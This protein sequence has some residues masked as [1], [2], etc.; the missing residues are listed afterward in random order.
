MADF[1]D[2]TTSAT[3]IQTQLATVGTNL[4]QLDRDLGEVERV[5]NR[6]QATTSEARA[7]VSQSRHDL[8]GSSDSMRLMLVLLGLVVALGQIVPLWLGF[9][10]TRGPVI[11]AAAEVP[12]SSSPIPWSPPGL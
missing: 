2:L 12:V 3:D 7:R 11:P 6:Y 9:A 8:A 1:T 4:D 10:L 5:I